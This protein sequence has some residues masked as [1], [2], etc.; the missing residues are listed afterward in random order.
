VNGSSV[1]PPA[2]VPCL[3]GRTYGTLFAGITL[4]VYPMSCTVCGQ[5]TCN[6]SCA[7]A[8][9]PEE[10]LRQGIKKAGQ[11]A[12]GDTLPDYDDEDE[13]TVEAD[14]GPSEL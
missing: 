1:P 3:I 9:S 5:E 2:L 7:S 14:L 12:P 4:L 8:V 13:D 10:R 11:R 6:G